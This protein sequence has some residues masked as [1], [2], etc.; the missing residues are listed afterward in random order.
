[1]L[2]EITF[3]L[4]KRGCH[5][6]PQRITTGEIAEQIGVSQ[7]TASRKLIQLE[8]LTMLRRNGGR[9]FLTDKAVVEARRL[10]KE[11]LDSLNGTEMSFSGMVVPGL[12]E[13]AF[14]LGMREYSVQ[15]EK[16]LGFKPHP[17]TL[18]I[19]IP[20][21]D[22][23]K[24]ITLRMQKGIEIEGFKK[25]HNMYGRVIAYPC[26]VGGIPGAIV[27]PELSSHGLQVLEII[28]PVNLMKKLKLSESDKVQVVVIETGH[29][30]TSHAKAG[31][32]KGSGKADN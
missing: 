7:Q 31:A 20:A 12:G 21:D 5:K 15:F 32:A 25:G 28:A 10:V 13:G 9:L 1:M 24:R 3:Y 4:L 6:E 14:F 23:E 8:K 17:G 2:S 27:F 26:A 16:K 19:S 18:N 11:I 29:N 30:G 22:I